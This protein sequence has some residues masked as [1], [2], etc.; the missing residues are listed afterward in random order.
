MMTTIP[1]DLEIQRFLKAADN[2]ANATEDGQRFAT[3]SFLIKRSVALRER[4]AAIRLRLE[5]GWDWLD[6]NPDDPDHADNE[7]RLIAWTVDY[8]RICDALNDGLNRWLGTPKHE[9]RQ[10][11]A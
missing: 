6:E 4:R 7:D 2:A 11:A 9:P 5:T 3:R 10:E 1:L 8:E